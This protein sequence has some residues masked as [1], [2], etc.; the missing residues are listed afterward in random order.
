MK[1]ILIFL[2]VLFFASFTLLSQNTVSDTISVDTLTIKKLEPIQDSIVFI[3]DSI[4]LNSTEEIYKSDSVF[5]DSIEVMPKSDSVSIDSVSLARDEFFSDSLNLN[6]S[7]ALLD[8]IQISDS[9]VYESFINQ[10]SDSLIFE[11]VDSVYFIIENFNKVIQ[12]DSI[13]ENDTIYMAIDKILDYRKNLQANSAIDYIQNKIEENSLFQET[14]SIGNLRNDTILKSLEY[15]VNSFPEKV[16]ELTFSNIM[17]DSVFMSFKESEKDSIHFKLYDNRGESAVLWIKK[18]DNKKFKLE[19]QEGTYIEKTKKRKVVE[20]KLD[21]YIEI[22]GLRKIKRVKKDIPI[23]RYGGVADIKF[24]Q[25]HISKSWA[26]GGESS[27]SLLSILKYNVNY[28]Y[29]KKRSFDADFEYRLGYLKAGENQL[30][31]NDDKIELNFK[32]GRSAF[33]KWY[34]SGLLNFKSQVLKG[35]EYPNDSTSIAISEFLSPASV[36]FSIG[37]DYKPSKK[38]TVLISPVTSK[39]TIVAD[40]INYDQTRF[41]LKEDEKI[42]KEIGAYVKAISIIKFKNNILLENK[43]NFFTNYADKPQNIDVDWEANL[44]VKLTDYIQMSINAHF[45]Y[46]DNI[47]FIDEDGKERGARPQFK[48]LFGIGFTYSF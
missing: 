33:N 15:I 3:N 45:I 25:G 41:G 1:R 20:Q 13:F 46:D 5:N 18:T 8:S 44:V 30:Q 19:L 34:Y 10:L 29:G 28:T 14:D 40:T 38:L 36:V 6:D 4:I 27:L 32:Y 24:S 22:P 9:L 23:W 7:I 21:T 37:L 43:V 42:R 2:L 39:F 31:K 17:K 12:Q 35:Y 26:E 48:E 47:S 16:M 11:K